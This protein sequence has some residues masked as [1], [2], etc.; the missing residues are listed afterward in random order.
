MRSTRQRIV[1]LLVWGLVTAGWLAAETA[2]RWDA[3]VQQQVS[4][5]LAEKDRLQR[6]QASVE[7]GIVTL[8]GTVDLYAYKAEAEKRV[9]GVAHVA[10]VRNR[11]DVAGARVSDAQLEDRLARRLRYDRSGYDN[12]FNSLSLAVERGVVT[13]SGT[14]RDYPARNSALALIAATPG[15]R[16]VVDQVRVA[17]LS[18]FDDRLR[19]AVARAVYGS[20]PSGEYA[21]DPQRP[22]RIVVVHGHVELDG[23]V[24]N[25]ADKIVAGLRAGSVPGVFS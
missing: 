8:G 12:V 24:A 19:I 1:V 25:Q 14:V 5:K 2:G 4:R 3:Q 22:I 9:R 17:P 7:D 20:L 10:G 23:V 6:V 16:D 11:I 13:L 18:I 21:L 15:V